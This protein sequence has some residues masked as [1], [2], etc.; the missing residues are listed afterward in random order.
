MPAARLNYIVIHRGQSQ[1]LG[2][3]SK[4]TA[5][6][7]PLPPGADIT[8]RRV[9]FITFQPDDEI[10]SVHKIPDEEVQTAEVRVNKVPV[11]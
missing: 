10:L 4:E 6:A 3:A 1:V 9:L 7:T 2:T 8:D 11:A 5:L